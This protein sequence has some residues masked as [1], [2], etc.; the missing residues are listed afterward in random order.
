MQETIGIDPHVSSHYP[1]FR[2]NVNYIY[3]TSHMQ[4]DQKGYI[5]KLLMS[6]LMYLVHFET[7]EVG[8]DCSVSPQY[9]NILMHP[10]SSNSTFST[11][12]SIATSYTLFSPIS[13]NKY[14]LYLINKV[15]VYVRG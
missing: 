14:L 15:V 8:I 6:S 10:E 11:F 13:N 1:I 5:K 9:V 7:L 2:G 12:F 4:F 3:S